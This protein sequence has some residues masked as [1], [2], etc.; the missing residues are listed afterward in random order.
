MEQS[1]NSMA[2]QFPHRGGVP[3]GSHR[4]AP[5]PTDQMWQQQALGGLGDSSHS[6]NSYTDVWDNANVIV[7]N[8]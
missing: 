8:D 2:K 3:L 4:P 1:E 7:A 5:T 6:A